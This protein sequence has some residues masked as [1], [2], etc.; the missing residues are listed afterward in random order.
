MSITTRFSEIIGNKIEDY[1]FHILGCGSIGSSV[2]TQ[3]ARMGA[4]MFQMYVL[5]KPKI[6][7]YKKFLY[8]DEE[9][10]EEPCTAKATPWC[11]SLTG[12]FI[13]NALSKVISGHPC[14]TELFFHFPSMTMDWK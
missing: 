14:P 4:E 3:L 7:E 11:S 9:G 13:S 1:A 12:S 8:Y 6:K 2:A 5:Q 10:S